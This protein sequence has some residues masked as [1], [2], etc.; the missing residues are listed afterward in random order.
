M[1][2]PYSFQF[3]AMTTPCELMI[4]HASAQDAGA[5]ARAIHSQTK[6]LEEKFNF[7]A[8]GS[9]LN[10]AINERTK[11]CVEVDEQTYRVLSQVRQLSEQTDGFFDICVGSLRKAATQFPGLERSVLAKNLAP[12]MG[13]EA[14]SL[15][16][17]AVYFKDTRTC[18]DLGGVI[19]EFAVDEAAKLTA[20]APGGSLVSFGGDM[21]VTGRKADGSYIRVG[22]RDPENKEH[23]LM[24]LAVENVAITT[25]GN[26]ERQTQVGGKKVGHIVG[27]G[28]DNRLLSATVIS[29]SAM[30]GGIF[31][32]A[33]V[34]KPDLVLPDDIQQVLIGADRKIYSDLQTLASAQSD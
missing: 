10:K 30:A 17:G 13:L 21:K 2:N 20:Q 15:H 7:H 5:I 29:D 3:A 6:A 28:G 24:T 23:L 1:L 14:W 25:S 19:K 33:L 27:Q 16:N 11:D 18:F 26:T 9:W 8:P 32:T 12:A 31:S 34:V 22:I 4:Y